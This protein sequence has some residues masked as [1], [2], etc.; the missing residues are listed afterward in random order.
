M[1]DARPLLTGLVDAKTG[2]RRSLP[3]AEVDKEKRKL[4]QPFIDSSL[5]T[6]NTDERTGNE[7]IELAHD[8]IITTWAPLNQWIVKDKEFL[9]W[10]QELDAKLESWKKSGET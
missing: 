8:L 10:R 9:I 6:F 4:L 1:E 3:L 7:S 2:R 5:L